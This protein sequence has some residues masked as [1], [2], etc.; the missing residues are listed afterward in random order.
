MNKFVAV[1]LLAAVASAKVH[2]EPLEGVVDC[3]VDYAPKL[4]QDVE[5]LSADVQNQDYAAL[6]ADVQVLS[7]DAQAA[8]ACFKAQGARALQE[9][10]NQAAV[11]DTLQC[12]TQFVPKIVAEAT[13]LI[14]DYQSLNYLALITD[15]LSLYNDAVGFVNCLQNKADLM[16]AVEKMMRIM[17]TK[18]TFDCIFQ[19]IPALVNDAKAIIADSQAGDFNALIAHV[20]QLVADGQAFAAC[21][22]A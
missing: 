8:L 10:A 12:I 5:K 11:E 3:L 14:A 16:A 2:H 6:F 22:Q 4:V 17:E 1:L 18:G 20:Q 13:K 7:T 19:Y 15:A 21:I 9:K